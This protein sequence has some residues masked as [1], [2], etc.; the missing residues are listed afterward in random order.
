MLCRGHSRIKTG[1]G[2]TS[3]PFF[4]FRRRRY[5]MSRLEG[6]K[7]IK[8][9]VMGSGGVGK[10]CLLIGY[11]QHHYVPCYDCTIEDSYRKL[12]TVDGVDAIMEI[13]EHYDSDYL[14]IDY[15]LKTASVVL[16]CFSVGSR[17]SFNEAIHGIYPKIRSGYP[18]KLVLLVGLQA[19]RD[20][21]CISQGEGVQA[22]VRTQSYGYFQCS[23]LKLYGIDSIFEEAARAALQASQR[24]PKKSGGFFSFFSKRPSSVPSTLPEKPL[25]LHS[26]TIVQA[27]LESLPTHIWLDVFIY[28]DFISLVKVSRT[29][30]KFYQLAKTEP[31]W[32][33]ALN[34][35]WL[36]PNLKSD[37]EWKNPTF[38]FDPEWTVPDFVLPKPNPSREPVCFGPRSTISLVDGSVVPLSKL[39]VGDEVSTADG[40]TASVSCIWKCLLSTPVPVITVDASGILEITADHPVFTNN[41]WNLPHTLG[42]PQLTDLEYV[43]NLSIT[44]HQKIPNTPK[45]SSFHQHQELQQESAL[46]RTVIVGGVTC[47]TL[48]MPVPGYEDPFWGSPLVTEWLRNRPDFPYVITHYDP[49]NR[50]IL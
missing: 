10:T 23:A 5:P 38:L 15:W 46:S 28:L 43:V 37:L 21:R 20:D 30:I 16:L 2:P 50:D 36:I 14:A 40:G 32:T 45:N 12:V 42:K 25:R 49:C 31:L 44:P 13:W 8:V 22:A 17:S 24:K 19:D 47:C 27:R 18:M 26:T 3:T 7:H 34:G 29:C 35:P 4:F 33:C 11:V 9:S 6:R 48:G 39:R 41:T 1:F